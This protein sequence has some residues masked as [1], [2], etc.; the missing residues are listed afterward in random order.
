MFASKAPTPRTQA[1][2]NPRTGIAGTL[3][4]KVRRHDGSLHL[5]HVVSD[6]RGSFHGIVAGFGLPRCPAELYKRA[7]VIGGCE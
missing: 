7:F 5:F 2:E 3:K 4:D 6:F 1:V